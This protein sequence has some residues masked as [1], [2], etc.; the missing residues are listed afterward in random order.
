MTPTHLELKNVLG[1]LW[2]GF[3]KARGGWGRGQNARIKEERRGGG[4]S[5]KEAPASRRVTDPT[6]N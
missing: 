5:Q 4:N 2:K 3:A 6:S 1:T